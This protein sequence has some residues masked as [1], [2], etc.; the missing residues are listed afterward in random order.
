[1]EIKEMERNCVKMNSLP[2]SCSSLKV[3]QQSP[4]AVQSSRNLTLMETE[5]TLLRMVT[6]SRRQNRRHK[7]KSV[8]KTVSAFRPKQDMCMGG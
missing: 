7:D 2:S 1:M 4:T 5:A 8:L 3:E 6:F